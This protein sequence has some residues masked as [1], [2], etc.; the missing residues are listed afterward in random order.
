MS[1][2]SKIIHEKIMN[3]DVNTQ[4]KPPKPKKQSL[5]KKLALYPFKMI[6]I[7]L[8]IDEDS[9][10]K[11][12]KKSPVHDT[13]Y[14]DSSRNFRNGYRVDNSHNGLNPYTFDPVEFDNMRIYLQGQ[15]GRGDP[16]CGHDR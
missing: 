2:T 7:V 15:D 8:G 9:L 6:Q 10:H 1:E 13:D 16:S 3:R 12:S 11:G 14:R 5:L 4:A